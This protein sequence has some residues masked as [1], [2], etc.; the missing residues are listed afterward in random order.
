MHSNMLFG[1]ILSL[2]MLLGNAIAQSHTPHHQQS[3][4]Q[5]TAPLTSE[6]DLTI[7]PLNE[8]ARTGVIPVEIE[9]TI[10]GCK[11]FLDCDSSPF[12][13]CR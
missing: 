6:N 9:E 8:T 3:L 11:H 2:S 7:I 5:F 10:L 12:Y 4:V 13:L 1:K